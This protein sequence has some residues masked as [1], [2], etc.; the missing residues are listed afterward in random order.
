M[1]NYDSISQEISEI[2]KKLLK[3]SKVDKVIGFGL[4]RFTKEITPIFIKK[5]EDADRLIFN[6][7]CEMSLTK[8]LL[9]YKGKKVAIVAKPCDSRAINAYLSEDLIKREDLVII[10]INGCPGIEGNTACEECNIRNAVICDYSVGQEM[11]EEEIQ[12]EIEGF[13]DEID[14]MNQAER[15]AYFQNEFERCTRCYAC[16]EA[17]YVCNCEQCFTDSNKPKWLG[18][19]VKLN[20]NFTYHLMRGIHMAGRCVNC[21]A[22]EMACPEGIDVRAFAAKMC[23]AAEEIF[24]YKSGM[25][26]EQKTLLSE[27]KVD[28]SEKGFME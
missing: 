17:C 9:N 3:E 20:D 2:A 7:N 23:S 6:K 1:S 8:Y 28:D 13:E 11:S 15:L 16:R 21:G 27:Y 5:A 14:K 18:E 4:G 22:C 12:A 26:P 10:G 25:D 24:D 19:S